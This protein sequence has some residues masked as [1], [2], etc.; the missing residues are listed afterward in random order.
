MSVPP[1]PAIESPL[2][3]PEAGGVHVEPPPSCAEP[4][5]VD[6]VTGG[7]TITLVDPPPGDVVRPVFGW[8]LVDGLVC[9]GIGLT[10]RPGARRPAMDRSW[11]AAR[12]SATRVWC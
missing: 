5:S 2:S 10:L 4:V 11:A 6:S 8:P 7:G 12:A 1:A 9:R 3:P